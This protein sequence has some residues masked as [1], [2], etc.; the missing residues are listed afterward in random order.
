[1][2]S[3]L[4]QR[5]ATELQAL[6]PGASSGGGVGK[7]SAVSES[8]DSSS[9]SDVAPDAPLVPRPRS[10]NYIED[11]LLVNVS[12]LPLRTSERVLQTLDVTEELYYL[13]RPSL[14]LTMIVMP[15]FA[16]VVLGSLAGLMLSLDIVWLS[17]VFAVLDLL[18][19]VSWGL[20]YARM[21]WTAYG[22]TSQRALVIVPRVPF[23]VKASLVSVPIRNLSRVHARHGDVV[24]TQVRGK[25]IGFAFVNNARALAS[26]LE[27]G[28]CVFRAKALLVE[29]RSSQQRID[30]EVFAEGPNPARAT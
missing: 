11:S 22:L 7:S 23:L 16:F 9:I 13:S 20:F 29:Q 3:S 15:I 25:D 21:Y 4:R 2:A 18:W 1:M 27:E 12:G 10:Y 8:D 6:G 17:I 5:R 19:A 26:A 24:L 30:A 14:P 28:L